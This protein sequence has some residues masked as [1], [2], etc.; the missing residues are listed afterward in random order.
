MPSPSK[1]LPTIMVRT[2]AAVRS[3]LM[4]APPR[5]TSA[6]PTTSS[7][8]IRSADFR[9]G[10]WLP[11]P[12]SGSTCGLGS[13]QDCS[14]AELIG[15]AGKQDRTGYPGGPSGAGEGTGREAVVPA[16]PR[17]T[18]PRVRGYG[19]S[20]LPDGR[21]GGGCGGRDGGNADDGAGEGPSEKT[22]SLGN[23]RRQGRKADVGQRPHRTEDDRGRRGRS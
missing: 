22:A 9:R 1:P 12:G 6:M 4:K 8:T 2:T 14:S 23:G 11:K 17:W 18:K 19:Q 20:G 7:R 21:G 3:D 13:F 15:F 10:V 16:N 5:K